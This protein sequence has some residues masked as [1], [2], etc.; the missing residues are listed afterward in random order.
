VLCSGKIGQLSNKN[1]ENKNKL[2]LQAA[3]KGPSHPGSPPPVG[4]R[5]SVK[6]GRN[7]CKRVNTG[8]L[9]QSNFKVPHFLLPTGGAVTVAEYCHVDVF[10][11]GLLSNM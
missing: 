6:S 3:M 9:W 5:K 11:P 10:R 8:Q 4:L 1:K 7:A 2:K